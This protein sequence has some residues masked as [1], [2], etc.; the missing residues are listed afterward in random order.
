MPQILK[1]FFDFF[2]NEYV[3]NSKELAKRLH[4]QQKKPKQVFL[5]AVE[6]AIRSN[7][8]YDDKIV[9][10]KIQFVHEPTCVLFI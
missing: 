1:I 9:P 2:S 6:N 10:S 8:V 5:E 4:N 3:K 7:V